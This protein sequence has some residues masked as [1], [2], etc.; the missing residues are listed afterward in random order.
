MILSC[1]ILSCMSGNWSKSSENLYSSPQAQKEKQ[2]E[3]GEN[4]LGACPTLSPSVS[5]SF[6]PSTSLK[7]S[8]KF[9][10]SLR[11]SAKCLRR[12][13]SF[14]PAGRYILSVGTCLYFQDRLSYGEVP[15]TLNV[16]I[17]KFEEI[18]CPKN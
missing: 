5:L 14:C 8:K 13:S 11:E 15:Y 7:S 16:K 12:D 10:L 9:E 1:D 17:I 18:G 2:N 3:K 4:G 6:L